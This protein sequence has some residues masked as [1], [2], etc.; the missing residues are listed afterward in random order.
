M[1]KMKIELKDGVICRLEYDGVNVGCC[2]IY[3]AG[4]ICRECRLTERG[5]DGRLFQLEYVQ[6]LIRE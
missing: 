1:E 2:D 3:C 5:F 4:M 6:D